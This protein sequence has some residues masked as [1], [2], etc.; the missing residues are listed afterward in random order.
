MRSYLPQLLFAAGL[1]QFTVLMASALVPLKLDWTT[2]L[3]PLPRLVRQL[4]WVYGGYVVLAIVGLG[5]IVVV[6]ASEL[7]GGSLLARSVCGY[8]AAFWGIRLA[9]QLVL[10]ARPYLTTWWLW[11]GEAVVTLIFAFLTA[12]YLLAALWP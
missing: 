7:A 2:Q 4:F 11:A 10:D 1:I 3:A 9:L 8:L 5:L 6:N 12:V